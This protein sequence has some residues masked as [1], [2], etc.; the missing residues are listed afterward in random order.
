MKFRILLLSLLLGSTLHIQAHSH[1]FFS[2]H[3]ITTN[4]TYELALNN[5]LIYNNSGMK[6]A[7][8]LDFFAM[9]LYQ[10]ST[11]AREFS[12]YFLPNNKSSITVKEDGTGDVDSI[13][14]GVVGPNNTSFSSMFEIRP[15]RSVVGADF[16]FHFPLDYVCNNLWFGVVFAAIQA[17]HTL[18]IEETDQTNLGS[19][20]G[21][22]DLT[23]ALTNSVYTQGRFYTGSKKRTGVDDVQFK[24]GYDWYFCD[25]DHMTIYGVAT[26]PTG[27]KN[28]TT[29]IFE[30]LVGTNHASLGFGFNGQ[31]T[32]WDC[33]AS[34]LVWMSDFKY[35]YY[36]SARELR[37]FDFIQNGDWSRYLQVVTELAPAVSTP[38]INEFTLS[39]KVTPGNMIYFWTALH[40]DYCCWD[41]ELGYTLWW[42]Q[43]EKISAVKNIP[44]NLGILDLAGLCSNPTSASSA[45]ISQSIVPPNMTISDPSFRAITASNIDLDSAAQPK[46]L[47]NTI[48]GASGYNTGMCNDLYLG[49]AGSYEFA[50]TCSVPST[51]S[52]WGVIGFD[53]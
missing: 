19:I 47:T 51:W 7:C 48:Y 44:T 34:S 25:N 52:V 1:S 49:V 4:S 50:S 31:Y 13:W 42:Q 6:D 28:N 33:E 36:F 38:A 37:S 46:S 15:T 22:A 12:K 30:P 26:A 14:F 41:F 17:K 16:S 39:A 40:Y 20:P 32:L 45:N 29:Y 11:K 21:F 3:Q 23:Q 27:E 18:H 5:Y 53:F 10:K 9:P 43:K 35:L 24:L 2:P 8:W